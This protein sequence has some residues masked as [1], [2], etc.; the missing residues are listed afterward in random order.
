MFVFHIFRNGGLNHV[1][2]DHQNH[3]SLAYDSGCTQLMFVHI[4]MFH[5][6][7]YTLY[8][9]KFRRCSYALYIC[10]YIY[11]YVCVCVSPGNAIVVKSGLV[12][13]R[14]RPGFDVVLALANNRFV[15]YLKGMRFTD[16]FLIF[17]HVLVLAI[18]RPDMD[19][20]LAKVQIKSAAERTILLGFQGGATIKKRCSLYQVHNGCR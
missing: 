11:V 3:G 9:Y 17:T 6:C 16:L 10:M 20:M 19:E 12:V 2:L 7:S 8:I 5:R 18:N 13:E 14:Y 15:L 1:I 4:Y